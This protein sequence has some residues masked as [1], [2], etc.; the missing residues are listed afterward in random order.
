MSICFAVSEIDWSLTKD[1]FSIVGT[2]VS[3]CGVIAAIVFG[4]IGLSTWRRQA[5][6]S[7]DHELSRRILLEL[8]RYKEA[9]NRA[10]YP[11][12]YKHE[13]ND[14]VE[15]VG[16]IDYQVMRFR[17][18]AKMYERR[19]DEII[20]C[21]SELGVSLVEGN[22]L[23]R[24][25]LTPMFE[26]IE[27]LELQLFQYINTYLYSINPEVPVVTREACQQQL[28]GM[29]DVLYDDLSKEGDDY[30]KK[31]EVCIDRIRFFLVSK[32]IH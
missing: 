2:V 31:M 24:D 23:W 22:A 13:M 17:R 4:R 18:L 7:N 16:N 1:A 32:M 11:S 27:A 30:R 14:E 3:A 5:K 28:G 8:Y 6:G 21:R 10:R 19:L 29:P 20:V 12:F 26:E 15:V 25:A 9:I